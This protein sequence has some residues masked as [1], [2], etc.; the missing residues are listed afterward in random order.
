[1][2]SVSCSSSHRVFGFIVFV[3]SAIWFMDPLSSA[4]TT[5]SVPAMDSRSRTT[6]SGRSSSSCMCRTRSPTVRFGAWFTRPT[7]WPACCCCAMGCGGAEMGTAG[8]GGG[9]SE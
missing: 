8:G 2:I 7:T 5:M 4:T 1:M 9:W 3:G 6:S